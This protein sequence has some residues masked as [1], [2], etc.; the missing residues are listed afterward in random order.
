MQQFEWIHAA[1]LAAFSALSQA[2]VGFSRPVGR[3]WYRG[4]AGGGLDPLWSTAEQKSWAG[5]ILL[6]VGMILI[7]LA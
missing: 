1:W 2:L 5:L 3:L 6:I 7:K 4:H